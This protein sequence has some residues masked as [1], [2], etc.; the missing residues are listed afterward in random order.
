MS[1][2]LDEDTAR[3][4]NSGRKTIGAMLSSAQSHLKKVF[5]LFVIVLLATI[6]GLQTFIWDAFKRDLLFAKMDASVTQATEVIAVTPFDVILLQVKIGILVGAIAATPLLLYYSRDALEERGIWP[7]GKISR[8]K[9]VAVGAMMG[10]LSLGGLFYAYELFFPI[11]FNFLA[12]NAVKAGFEPTYSIVK[13]TEFIFFLGLSFGLAAQLPL[14]MSGTAA[15]GVVRYETFRDKWRYAVMGI[16][17]FGALF[18]PPD[19]FTQIMWAVPLVSLYAV[20]LGVTRLVVLSQRAGE[21]VPIGAVVRDRWNLLAGGFLVGAVA[22]YAYLTRG[23]LAATN[24][25]L[26]TVGST[27]RFPTAGELGAVGLSPTAVAIIFAVVGGLVVFGAALFY[28]RIA[29]LERY[30]TR[31]LAPGEVPDA[32]QTAEE[33]APSVGEPA[34]IDIDALS[35]PAVRAAPVEAFAGLSETEAL[36]HAE[37]A[38]ENGQAEKAQLVL[39]R[40]DEAQE[41]DAQAE[42][43]SETDQAGDEE[44]SDP[45]TST[46]AGMMGA[47]TDEETTEDDIGGYYYDIRFVLDSLT[48]KAIWIVAVFMLVLAGSFAYLYS[49]GIGDIKNTFLRSM[50]PGLAEEVNVVTLHPVEA[51]IFEVKFSTLLAFVAILPLVLY[52]AWPAIEE[53][54]ITTGDRGVLGIW[55]GTLVATLVGGTLLGFFYISPTAIGWLATDALTSAMVIAYRINNFGWLVIFTTVGIGILVEIP[56]TMLLFHRGRIVPYTTMRK[57]WRAV[58]VGFFAAAGFFSPD[59]VFTMFLLAIPASLAYGTGLGLLWLY[60]RVA[61]TRQPETKGEPAD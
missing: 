48:S 57:Y 46:A 17:A 41:T 3:T 34:S 29:A 39:D 22:V 23:G 25:L 12:S 14:G 24:R 13:W 59:G 51:L 27:R 54:G 19:P 61:G 15:A 9:L 38:M 5:V 16:F 6:Y 58:V 60:T 21:E 56:I 33:T 52:F 37:R 26:E 4:L 8:W 50:P 49:G 2:A 40:F 18:S 28:F 20:S 10:L 32:E 35:A 42:E 1:R 45:L 55:G 43:D 44:E 7:D 36:E 31:G 53:R 30:T 11:M 47:F